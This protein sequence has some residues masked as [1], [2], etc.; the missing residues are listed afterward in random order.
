MCICINMPGC[1]ISVPE[2]NSL[3]V[4][5]CSERDKHEVLQGGCNRGT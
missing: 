2:Q 4:E 3:E 5:K 1:V